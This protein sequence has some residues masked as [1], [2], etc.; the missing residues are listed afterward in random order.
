M[1]N[2]LGF[3]CILCICLVACDAKSPAKPPQSAPNSPPPIAKT[4]A[5]EVSPARLPYRVQSA[6][7]NWMRQVSHYRQMP[8]HG[9]AC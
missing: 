4:L 2:R 7:L 3:S 8:P 9:N 5:S 1:L 6:M